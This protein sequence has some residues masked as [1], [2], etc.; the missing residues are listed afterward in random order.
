MSQNAQ[1]PLLPSPQSSTSQL[2]RFTRATLSVVVGLFCFLIGPQRA[3]TQSA[4]HDPGVRSGPSGA[5][6]PIAGLTPNQ[7]A[8]FDAGLEDFSEIE[9]VKGTVS[10]TGVGLGPRFNG[11]S[12]AQCHAQPAAGG[13]SPPI[14]PR[15]LLPTI[16]ELPTRYPSSSP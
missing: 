11:E 4:A 10:N 2:P 1:I 8:Y 14:T 9:S 12:C 7:R 6:A 15:S 5:G 3:L 16:K 13:S